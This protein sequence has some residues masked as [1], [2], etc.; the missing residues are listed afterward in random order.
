MQL[1]D[2]HAH[3]DDQAFAPDRAAVVAS[4]A[5][6]GVGMIVTVGTS[7]DSSWAAL[8]LAE[9]FPTVRAA[10]GIHPHEA[11]R[12]SPEAVDALRPL[13]A[14]P[15]VVAVGET[16]LDFHRDHAPRDA[17]VALFRAHLALAMAAGLPVVVHCRDAHDALLGTLAAFPDVIV[18]MHAFS[19]PAEVA[20]E[21]LRRGYY[22]SFAGPITFPRAETLRN[23]AR[24]VPADRLLVET[25]APSLS[26]VPMRGRRNEPAHVRLVV[27]GLA[28]ARGEMYAAVAAATAAYARRVFRLAAEV[29]A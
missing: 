6:A 16:G 2:S 12:V 15:A 29:P 3:L 1:T 10:A 17:Q 24:T 21:C 26:P 27:E 5:Q 19:G 11:G 22:L 8:R 18:V 9:A 28:A 23:V 4:A 25:D 13:L 14:H 20:R 7:A